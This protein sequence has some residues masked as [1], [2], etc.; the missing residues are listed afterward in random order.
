MKILSQLKNPF[1]SNMAFAFN[2]RDNLYLGMD[3]LQGG[4]LR[5]FLAESRK[6]SE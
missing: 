6:L 4:D 2:D 3:Y 5:S 1:I